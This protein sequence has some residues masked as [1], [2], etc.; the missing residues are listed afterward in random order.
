MSEHKLAQFCFGFQ[1][2]MVFF[3][4]KSFEKCWIAIY[5]VLYFLKRVYFG[6]FI[7]YQQVSVQVVRHQIHFWGLKYY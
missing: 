5:K 2:A 6:L 1:D 7:L 4:H 3:C